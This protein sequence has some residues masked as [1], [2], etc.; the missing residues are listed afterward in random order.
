MLDGKGVNMRDFGAFTFEVFSDTVK[1]AQHSN[2]DIAKELDEQRIDRKH[3]HAI[4]PCFVPD[5][6]FRSSLMRYP[7]KEEITAPK[8]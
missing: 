8:S 7:G 4:R 1:P 2:F 5:R 6:K 3:V